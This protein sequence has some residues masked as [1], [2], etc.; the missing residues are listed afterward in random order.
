MDKIK[1]I[2]V[3]M[4]IYLLRYECVIVN[5]FSKLELAIKELKLYDYKTIYFYTIREVMR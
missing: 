5:E 1:D 4:T 3:L 2:P